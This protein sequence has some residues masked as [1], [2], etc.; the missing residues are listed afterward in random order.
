MPDVQHGE[1]DKT[2]VCD[3]KAASVPGD[4]SREALGQDDEDV[5][6]NSIVA[7]IG[8]PEGSVRQG[9]PT[10]ATSSTSAHEADMRY[11]DTSPGNESGDGTDIEE[12]VELQSTIAGLVHESE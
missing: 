5:E 6:D 1:Q 8:V 7:E 11:V 4:E 12:P 9:F 2:D 3:E 10:D